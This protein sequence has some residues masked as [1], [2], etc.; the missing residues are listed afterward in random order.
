MVQ[1]IELATALATTLPTVT[2]LLKTLRGYPLAGGLAICIWYVWT[3][4]TTAVSV[5][6]KSLAPT[7]GDFWARRR[8]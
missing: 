2:R 6:Q 4:L 3:S 5:T 7:R 8:A 1:R